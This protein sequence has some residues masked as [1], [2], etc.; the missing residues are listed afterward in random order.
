MFTKQINS[1]ISRFIFKGRVTMGR[2][3]LAELSHPVEAGGLGLVDIQK[4]ADTLLLRQTCRMLCRRG[5]GFKHLSYWLSST[6]EDKITLH[7]GPRSFL[8]PP[9]LQQY[10]L[11]LIIKAREE[12]SES[13]L[14]KQTAKSLYMR[15]AEHLPAPRL[16]RNNPHVDMKPVW[17][18]ISSPVLGVREK[19]ALFIM[20]HKL[21]R[22]K[23]E[24]FLKW[25]QGDYTCE[26]SPDPEGR[27]AGHP[28][29]VKHMFQDCTR[30][31]GS[32]DW[33]FSYL[34]TF[35]PPA[36]LTEEDCITLIYPSLGNRQIEDSVSWL[37]GSYLVVMMEAAERGRVLVEEELRG[38]LRQKFIVY[39]MKRTRPLNLNNL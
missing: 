4:K 16:Q 28:Q 9:K 22:N 6:L 8:R 25:G 13:D 20:A 5:P 37:L 2:L 10:I 36:L 39:R 17:K 35:L 21:V 3:S 23:E 11:Q 30:V 18:R 12:M 7:H 26:H 32:W 27:C 19:H 14:M 31:A 34:S 38:H 29:S 33:L 1:E 15:E 24:M